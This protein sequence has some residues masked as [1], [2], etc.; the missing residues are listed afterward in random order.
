MI[1][2]ICTLIICSLNRNRQQEEP[3]TKGEAIAMVIVGIF[4]LA[5][6]VWAIYMIITTHQLHEEIMKKYQPQNPK[7]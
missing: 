1:P 7:L 2:A 5:F 3:A 4:F 6:I